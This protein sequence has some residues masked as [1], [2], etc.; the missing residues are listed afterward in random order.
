[1]IRLKSLS[2]F[3]CGAAALLPAPALAGPRVGQAGES[4]RATIRISISVAPRFG[5]AS[6]PTACCAP[7]A[8]SLVLSTNASGLRYAVVEASALSAGDILPPNRGEP[9]LVLITPD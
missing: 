4:S 8:A 3:C 9:R 7:D 1:M 5:A 6:R 2:T